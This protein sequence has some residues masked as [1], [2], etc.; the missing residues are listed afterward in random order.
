MAYEILLLKIV[1]SP[2]FSFFFLDVLVKVKKR[3]K[4]KNPIFPS[5]ETANKPK[6]LKLD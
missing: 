1:T 2:I 5:Q 4:P 6:G 3:S